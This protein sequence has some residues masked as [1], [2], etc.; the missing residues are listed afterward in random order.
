MPSH[1]DRRATLRWAKFGPP[2]RGHARLSRGKQRC[3]QRQVFQQLAFAEP[4]KLGFDQTADRAATPLLEDGTEG[5]LRHTLRS[6]IAPQ[7]TQFR[8]NDHPEPP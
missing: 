7:R 2:L 1:S 8:S 5:G 4:A 6:V 3:Q